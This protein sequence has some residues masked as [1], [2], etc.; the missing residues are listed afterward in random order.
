MDQDEFTVGL[1]KLRSSFFSKLSTELEVIRLKYMDQLKRLLDDSSFTPQEKEE[2]DN[3]CRIEFDESCLFKRD[4]LRR[5][6]LC[7]EARLKEIFDEQR[8]LINRI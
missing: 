2:M 8:V 1:E 6:W 5:R 4:S 7:H 3:D